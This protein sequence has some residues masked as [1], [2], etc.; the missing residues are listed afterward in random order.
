MQ[1]RF[2]RLLWFS[3]HFIRSVFLDTSNNRLAETLQLEVRALQAELH[4]TQRVLAG[5]SEILV[6]CQENKTNSH[7]GQSLF[8]FFTSCLCLI[9]I[10]WIR[11]TPRVLNQ[12]AVQGAVETGGSSDS[13][14]D[15]LPALPATVKSLV[16]ARPS[17]FGKGKRVFRQS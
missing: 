17:S 13:D 2:V 10:W 11:S 7:W 15:Q 6:R 12:P 14:L 8:L 4:H 5:Y 1:E 9:V 16:P 3:S